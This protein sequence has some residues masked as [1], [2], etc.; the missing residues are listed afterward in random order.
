MPGVRMQRGDWI[1]VCDGAKALVL[2]NI[3][4]ERFPN[5]RTRE[6]HAHKDRK[7]RDIGSD[8]AGRVFAS[9]GSAGGSMEETDWH[10]QAE[11]RFLENVAARLDVAVQSGEAKALIVVA[12]PRALGVLRAAYTAHV[13]N[14]LRAEIDKDYVK[15]PLHEIE[16]QLAA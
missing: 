3:G 14:V 11:R 5:L 7:S 8:A 16:E 13:R 4:N 12:P 2:E 10:E 9:V 15:L 6:V 1:L